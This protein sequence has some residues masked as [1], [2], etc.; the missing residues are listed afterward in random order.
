MWLVEMYIVCVLWEKVHDYTLRQIHVCTL[1]SIMIINHMQMLD[2][3]CFI[4]KERDRN[5]IVHRDLKPSNIF[6]A[7]GKENFLKIGDFG[8]VKGASVIDPCGEYE[9]KHSCDHV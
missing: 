6:F 3:L 7:R 4:H 1:C 9:S 8:L 5:R 2:A